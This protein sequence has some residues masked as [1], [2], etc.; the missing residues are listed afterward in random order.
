MCVCVCG[1]G[2][3]GG[4]GCYWFSVLRFVASACCTCLT[5]SFHLVYGRA[6][7]SVCMGGEGVCE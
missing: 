3:G 1:G 5:A 2:G 6:S 7:R 4:G